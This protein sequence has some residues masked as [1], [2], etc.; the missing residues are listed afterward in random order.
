MVLWLTQTFPRVTE[1][2]DFVNERGLA[3][4]QF[5]V[6]SARDARGAEEFYLLYTEEASPT[7]PAQQMVEADLLPVLG[8]GE[9]GA[10]GEAV[11][12]AQAIIQA[13]EGEEPSS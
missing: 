4:L 11:E 6:V 7:S 13:H 12:Q 9:G 5:K 8:E 10:A 2:V 1:L 3:A